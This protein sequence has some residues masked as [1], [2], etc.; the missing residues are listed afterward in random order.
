MSD[1]LGTVDLSHHLL[2]ENRMLNYRLACV[3]RELKQRD[4]AALLMYDP[5]NIRY[6]TD[7]SNMQV[8]G[9]HNPARYAFVA[10]EGP[11]I[12][13]E[14]PSCGTPAAQADSFQERPNDMI[15]GSMIL[16]I[17]PCVT[18]PNLSN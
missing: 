11:V 8:W 2:D 5:V 1:S 10:S 9:L 4:L 18:P 17:V 3:Q 13:F 12:L 16:P 6:A 7:V 14:F 15:F